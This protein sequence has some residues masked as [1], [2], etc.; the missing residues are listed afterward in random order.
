MKTI[1]IIL[2]K[3]VATNL[4]FRSG[5]CRNSFIIC[6]SPRTQDNI[7]YFN[8]TFEGASSHICLM[9]SFCRIQTLTECESKCRLLLNMVPAQQPATTPILFRRCC[10]DLN[11]TG[12]VSL[13]LEEN[14][15]AVTSGA[16]SGTFARV[17]AMFRYCWWQVRRSSPRS[18]DGKW[19]S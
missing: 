8:A 15:G 11:R 16:L 18:S 2:L 19:Y 10:T 1:D 9:Q 17:I 3:E 13:E 7:A 12:C 5:L 14:Q 6:I 4:T